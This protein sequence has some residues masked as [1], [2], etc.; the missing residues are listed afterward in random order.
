MTNTTATAE[1]FTAWL[2][3]D[4]S[5]LEGDFCDVVV[6][7]DEEI[8]EDNGKPAWS[9]VGTPVFRAETTVRHDADTYEGAEKQARELLEAAGW[10]VVGK[11][12]GV[13]TGGT[14]TVERDES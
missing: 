4:A 7:A 3:T 14:I 9:S 8:S 2:T 10:R 6:L 12:E 1:H 11:W 13:P 5:C